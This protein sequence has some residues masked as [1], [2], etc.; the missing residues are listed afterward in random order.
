MSQGPW[1]RNPGTGGSSCAQGLPATKA[2]AAVLCEAQGPFPRSRSGW[3][4]SVPCRSEAL[5]S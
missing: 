1:V 3:Q 4:T 2:E 5:G